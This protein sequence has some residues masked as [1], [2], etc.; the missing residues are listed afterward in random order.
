LCTYS[1]VPNFTVFKFAILE[2]NYIAKHFFDYQS[3]VNI[4]HKA[5]QLHKQPYSEAG[6]DTTAVSIEH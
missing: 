3:F 4:P 1:I 5:V 6:V 2:M